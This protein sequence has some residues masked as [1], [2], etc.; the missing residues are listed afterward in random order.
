MAV[1]VRL[2][3]TLEALVN[4]EARRLGVTKSQVIKDALERVFGI[5][6]PGVIL[7]AVRS[8]TP[9]GDPEASKNV[10]DKMKKQLRAKRS[11]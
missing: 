10:S 5:R 4:Q 7:K 11:P 2:D 1:S 9:M 6:N 3:P 8:G